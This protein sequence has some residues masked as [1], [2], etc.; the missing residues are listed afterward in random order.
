MAEARQTP[1]HLWVIGV[2]SLVWNGFG[3]FDYVMTE[4]RNADYLAQ[5]TE[6]QIAYFTGLPAWVVAFWA[7]GVWGAVLGSILLLL[8][9]RWAEPVFWLSVAGVIVTSAYT[10]LLTGPEAAAVMG[11]VGIAF[12]AV[13]LIVGVALA[14]YARAMRGRGVLA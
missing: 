1:W 4:T 5:L 2:A 8:R 11:A 13:I 3:A 10:F 6:E 14:L 7:I 9:R 12:S